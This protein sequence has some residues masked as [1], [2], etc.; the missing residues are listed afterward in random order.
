MSVF[1]S[2]TLR[3]AIAQKVQSCSSVFPGSR[4]SVVM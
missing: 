2:Q 1:S 4:G 3:R